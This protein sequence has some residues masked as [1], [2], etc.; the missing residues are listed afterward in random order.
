MSRI[1]PFYWAV[2]ITTLLVGVMLLLNPHKENLAAKDLPWNSSFNTEGKLEAL[3]L[4]LGDS[5]LKDAINLFGRDI[6]VRIFDFVD[7]EKVVEAYI[8]SAYI[9]TIHAAMVFKLALTPEEVEEFY[10]RGAR[11]TVTSQGAREV[12]L[13]SDDTLAMFDYKVREFSV[14]PRRNLSAEAVRKRFGEPFEIVVDAE[15]SSIEHWFYPAKGLDLM[16]IAG[17]KE[18]LRYSN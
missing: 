18:I 2:I 11:T 13:N 3:G 15:E 7:G 10:Q 12:Q 5:T 17:D 1:T 8:S 6:E 4:T 16:L 9:G 14:I